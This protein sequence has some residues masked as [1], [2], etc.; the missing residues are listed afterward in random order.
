MTLSTFQ[1]QMNNFVNVAIDLSINEINYEFKIRETLS[2]L[3]IEKKIVDLFAQRLKYR[4][5]TIDV[6]IFVNIKAKI[7]YDARHVSLMLKIENYAYLRLHHDY[8]L[9]DRFNKKI[10]QQ[11]C[12]SF[13]VKC[14]IDRLTYELNFLFV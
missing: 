12:D 5:E 11:R 10:N 13:F 3:I 7:Y 8:Q 1:I 2:N 14:R 4:R 9:L 6:T